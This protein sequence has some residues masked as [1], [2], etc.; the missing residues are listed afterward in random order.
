MRDLSRF[1]KLLRHHLRNGENSDASIIEALTT[2]YFLKQSK[3][4]DQSLEVA[5]KFGLVSENS[6]LR[7]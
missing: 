1:L 6:A 7:V 2:C 3:R 5:K 4:S